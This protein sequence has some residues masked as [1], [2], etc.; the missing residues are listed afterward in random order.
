MTFISKIISS[1]MTI[2]AL[3]GFFA[4]DLL[5]TDWLYRKRVESVQYENTIETAVPQTDLYSMVAEHFSSSL[6][7]G[8]TEKKAIIIGY[9]G[10]RADALAFAEDGESAVNKMRNE[11]A[12]CRLSYCG[13]V[14]YPE[15]NTQDTSTAPGWCSILTGQWADKTGITGNGIVKSMDTKTLMTDLTE[16]KIIDS[17]AFITSWNGHFVLSDST[18]KLEKQYCKDHKLAVDFNY[19]LTDTQSAMTAIGNIKRKN[20]SDFIF[21]I[22]EATDHNGHNYGFS[23]NNPKYVSGFRK[24]DSLAYQTIEAIESRKTYSTEDWLIILTADHGGKGTGHGDASLQERMT[25][26]I[27]NK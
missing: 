6:P 27:S 19:C 21:V 15:I 7:E 23:T 2:L 3:S 14:N 26:I 20:C 9:D 12:S 10:C 25:F 11:G 22:Y 8:K 16:R 5:D 4:N 17:A 24:N 1:V 13:G 18:Y